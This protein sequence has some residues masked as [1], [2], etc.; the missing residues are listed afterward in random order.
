MKILMVEDSATVAAYVTA[1]LGSEPDMQLLPVATTAKEGVR[2]TRELRPDVVLMDMRLP[3][4][5]GVWAIENIMMDSPCPIIVLSGYLSS[6]ER[7]I[8]FESLRAGAVEVLAKPTGL[9]PQVREAFRTDLV[10]T[11]RLMRSAV[12]VRRRA[13]SSH[14]RGTLTASAPRAVMREPLPQ[15]RGV[16][17]GASTGGPELLH[18]TLSA[19]PKP[20]PLP[21]LITQHTLEGFDGSLAEWLCTTGHNVKI[22]TEGTYPEPGEV[23]LAPADKHLCL[24]MHGITLTK[25]KR[26]ESISAIDAMF[27]SAARVW[28]EQALAILLTGMGRDGASGMR[29]LYE[30]GAFTVAQS[31]ETCIVAS[32]PESARAIGAVRHLMPPEQIV[33]L[34]LQVA[35]QRAEPRAMGPEVES[36]KTS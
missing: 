33:G 29:A 30:R 23:L 7:D 36:E 6:R 18:R 9:T 13:P 22:A 1:I 24:G 16:L 35:A 19:L 28:G 32:M 34:L 15:L 10:R 8:T 11:I 3:D 21:V 31:P 4:H 26:G 12:V 5:D 17:I 14:G 2:V 25:A 27:A 20:F